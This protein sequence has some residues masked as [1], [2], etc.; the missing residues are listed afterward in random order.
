MLLYPFPQPPQKDQEK[1]ELV[2]SQVSAKLRIQIQQSH[3]EG[4]KT[5]ALASCDNKGIRPCVGVS[6]EVAPQ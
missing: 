1:L 2:G 3:C 5:P 6:N 4:K